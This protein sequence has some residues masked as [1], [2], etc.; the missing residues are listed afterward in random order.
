M[1]QRDLIL[2]KRCHPFCYKSDFFESHGLQ[3][4][5][6]VASMDEAEKIARED[7]RCFGYYVFQ[8]EYFIL[9]GKR[10]EAK[11]EKIKSIIFGEILNL[12]QIKALPNPHHQEEVLIKNMEKKKQNQ[13]IRT[14]TGGWLNLEDEKDA[15]V[16]A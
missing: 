6:P 5:I 8:Q 14:R 16:V 7:N 13:A 1:K 4:E 2:T 15:K 10:F 12:E 11:P 9:K 3:P